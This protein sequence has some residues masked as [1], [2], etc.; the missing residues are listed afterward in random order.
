MYSYVAAKISPDIGG[1]ERQYPLKPN[2]AQAPKRGSKTRKSPLTMAHL[3]CLT[4]MSIGMS[5]SWDTNPI[6]CKFFIT[7]YD[8]IT[9]Q[10]LG[11]IYESLGLCEWR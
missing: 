6:L 9:A 3:I 11:V 2:M 1:N 5:R 4:Q 7:N 10:P 8:E